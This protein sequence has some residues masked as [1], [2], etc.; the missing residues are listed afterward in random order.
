M[1]V[2]GM[3]KTDQT[4]SQRYDYDEDGKPDLIVNYS[5]GLVLSSVEDANSDGTMDVLHRYNQGV[6]ESTVRDDNFD[7]TCDALVTY[8][9][10]SPIRQVVDR[11]CDGKVYVIEEYK[12][13]MLSERTWYDGGVGGTPYR[14]VLYERGFRK[15]ETIDVDM[16]GSLD[17]MVLFDQ[18]ENPI[19]GS[20]VSPDQSIR[21]TSAAMLDEMLD[22]MHRADPSR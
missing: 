5:N 1:F 12:R 11:N 10:G 15:A 13:R 14:Y 22:E 20:T 6:I 17:T 4:W 2:H 8:T 9:N 21:N 7:G 16:N 18:L 19:P 3:A